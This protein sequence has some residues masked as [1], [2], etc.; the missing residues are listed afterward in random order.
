MSKI[1]KFDVTLN[2]PTGIYHPGDV[3]SGTVSVKVR[4]DIPCNGKWTI[5]IQCLFS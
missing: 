3:L 4:E 5:I 2:N 1:I